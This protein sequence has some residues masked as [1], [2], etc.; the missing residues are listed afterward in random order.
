MKMRMREG[1]TTERKETGNI[2]Q[3]RGPKDKN[4]RYNAVHLNRYQ[5]LS[6]GLRVPVAHNVPHL[7]TREYDLMASSNGDLR[8]KNVLL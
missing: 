2:I 1:R 6:Q 8:T 3:T 7:P 4:Q 5:C